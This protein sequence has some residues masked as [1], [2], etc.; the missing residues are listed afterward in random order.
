MGGRGEP[1]QLLTYQVVIHIVQIDLPHS[2]EVWE[3]G[4]EEELVP[5]LRAGKG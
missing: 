4:P 1:S 5:E 3:T 2:G